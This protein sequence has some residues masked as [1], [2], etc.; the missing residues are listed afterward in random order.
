M[1]HGYPPWSGIKR[2]TIH[3][4]PVDMAELA[5][6]LGSIVT[7]DRR[8]Q[9]V[10]LEDFSRGLGSWVPHTS[11]TGAAVR[12]SAKQSFSPPYSCELVAGSD[13][14]R[15]A[16]IQRYLPFPAEHKMGLEASFTLDPDTEYVRV[17]LAWYDGTYLRAWQVNYDVADGELGCGGSDGQ[18]ETLDSD[19]DLRVSDTQFHTIK[20]VAD[21]ENEEF[22][23]V[24]CN[25]LTYIP[26]VAV[27]VKTADA[28]SP[29]LVLYVR[30]YSVAAPAVNPNIWTDNIVLTQNEP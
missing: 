18:Y 25:P 24:L 1:G 22:T 12:H 30:H 19:L 13:G 2:E 4:L 7:Y 11:G 3:A 9:V 27:I 6:R 28:S 21:L 20:L 14:D 23:R 17:I 10:F 29:H 16:E 5:A 26:E 8:G 15:Y